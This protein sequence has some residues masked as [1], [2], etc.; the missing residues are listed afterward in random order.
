M[1]EELTAFGHTIATYKTATK[2]QSRLLPPA[3]QQLFGRQYR[4]TIP[5]C[6]AVVSVVAN[7]LFIRSII[8]STD[9]GS[10]WA[11][12]VLK[13][14]HFDY[15]QRILWN[16]VVRDGVGYILIKP[17][18]TGVEIETI[19]AFDGN[20]GIAPYKDGFVYIYTNAE[21]RKVAE[22]Y[23]PGEI[24]YYL[25]ENPHW[26]RQKTERWLPKSLPVVSFGNYRSFIEQLLQLQDD[27]NLAILDI[28]ATGRGQGFP[29]R[30]IIGSTEFARNLFGQPLLDATG[31]PIRKTITIE[32]GSFLRFEEN[33]KVDQLP[34]AQ[35]DTKA[36]EQLIE[37]ITLISGIPS[38]YFRGQIPSGIA[39]QIAEQ[40]VNATVEQYQALLTPAAELFISSINEIGNTYSTYPK[41]D[42]DWSAIWYPP[43]IE[44]EELI[45]A[46]TERIIK[47]VEAGII[48]R[49]TALKELFPEWS[50]QKIEEELMNGER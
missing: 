43:Q 49:K 24:E 47:L 32:P 9:A 3:I 6:A 42:P 34:Q 39:L 22:Y 2:A 28:L 36:V 45:S 21:N 27:L 46:K 13:S 12:E 20:A 5:I 48:S 14:I 44:T 31:A 17:A 29:L 1:F 40:R 25:Y 50:E 35:I 18:E 41:I 15:W 4:A 30:Y 19:D 10:L 8:H 23:R 7:K 26:I 33:T 11:E 16:N 37:L 38:Y